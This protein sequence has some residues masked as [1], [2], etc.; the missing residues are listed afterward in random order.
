MLKLLRTGLCSLLLAGTTVF[1][2]HAEDAPAAPKGL[3]LKKGQRVA[4]IGDSITEQKQY[5]KFIELYLTACRPDLDLHVLQFGW[6]GETAGGFVNRMEN[7]LIPYKPDVATTCYGMNDG[8]YKAYEEG[9]G[10][11]YTANMVKIIER[12]KKE[13]ATVV[14]GTPGAVDTKYFRGGGEA[15]TVYNA[16]L[17]KLGEL[18]QELA[19]KYGMPFADVHAPM[20]AAMEKGK[21]ALGPDYD[22][23]GRDGVHP[24]ANGHLIMAYAFIKGMG[25]DGNLATFTVDMNGKAEASEGHTITSS[26]KGKVEIE[27]TRYPFCFFGDEKSPGGNRSILPFLPFNDDLNR[28]TLVVKNLDWDKAKV[29]WGA[30]SKTFTKAELAKGIN[31]AAEFIDNPF[32]EPFKKVGDAIS[33]KENYET[34]MIK[35]I[36]TNF[37]RM[38]HCIEGDKEVEAIIET[39]R[40]KLMGRYE[41][42]QSDTK[43]LV[44][45]VKHTLTITKE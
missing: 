11:G 23:C 28:F 30:G 18:D 33:G 29:T 8:G 13:G 10:K 42:L 44:V 22:V 43:A 26:E 16:T 40:T 19:T 37:P 32:S 9:T 3:I 14:V 21:A 6:G 38:K 25:F 20:I 1:S 31:L 4:V 27:S 2:L 15:P 24:N 41:K 35:G 5:S 17:K 12:V 7:D 39:L 45:P 34:D 36:I